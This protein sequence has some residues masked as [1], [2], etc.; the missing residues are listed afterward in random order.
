MSIIKNLLMKNL[1]LKQEI[2]IATALDA[3]IKELQKAI[4]REKKLEIDYSYYEEN[5]LACK[6]ALSV[7]GFIV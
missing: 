5:L 7:L 4:D 6:S 1:S 3:R 2:N